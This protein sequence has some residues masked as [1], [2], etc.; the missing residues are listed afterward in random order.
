MANKKRRNK[1]I[2]FSALGVILIGIIILISLPKKSED[3]FIENELKDFLNSNDINKT[4]VEKDNFS[5]DSV[6]ENVSSPVEMAALMLYLKVPFSKE[7][8][9]STKNLDNYNTAFKKAINLGILGADLGYLNMYNKTNV[10]LDY[11]SAIRDL[12]NDLHIGQFFDFTTLKR[13]VS[14]NTN[15]DSLM[16]ISVQSFNK[17]DRYLQENNS[18]NLSVLMISGVWIEGIYLVTQVYKEY[19]NVKIK[20]TIGDQKQ[21]VNILQSMI[22]KYKRDAFFKALSDDFTELKDIFEEV[23]ITIEETEPQMI[24]MNGVVTFVPGQKSVISISDETMK[25]I[26][27]K[28]AELRNKVISS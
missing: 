3:Q 4:E 5:M 18:R 28:I 10:V 19:P 24:E 16:L 11:I 21:I 27:E 23:K 26:T 12:A 17:M 9:S 13:L 15:L 25:K 2:I 20:E 8:L 1:Y 6:I 14:N 7:Y 22:F